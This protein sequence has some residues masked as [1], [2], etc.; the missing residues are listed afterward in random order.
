MFD[1]LILPK[2]KR[3]GGD[4]KE[5]V[6][7]KEIEMKRKEKQDEKMHVDMLKK[8]LE[9]IKAKNADL[10]KKV[11]ELSK[12]RDDLKKENGELKANTEVL[13]KEINCWRDNNTHRH[14]VDS[15]RA[16]KQPFINRSYTQV[17]KA[18]NEN[19]IREYEERKRRRARY[20]ILKYVNIDE[21]AQ[22]MLKKKVTKLLSDRGIQINEEDIRNVS[23]ANS[24][25]KVIMIEM[26]DE[27]SAK[28][29]LYQRLILVQA[30]TPF[31]MEAK[32]TYKER[33]RIAMRKYGPR[34]H[35]M[36]YRV[37]R[38]STQPSSTS[39]SVA[40]AATTS[41]SSSHS[42]S[43]G[44]GGS[45]NTPLVQL[46]S[47]SSNLLSPVTL[48]YNLFPTS[49]STCNSLHSSSTS[50]KTF[51]MSLSSSSYSSSTSSSQYSML[52]MSQSSAP[53]HSTQSSIDTIAL[54]SVTSTSLS[55]LS[56]PL[57]LSLSSPYTSQNR[58]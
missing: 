7:K 25:R 42:S 29:I 46:S 49:P 53:T 19:E 18:F 5:D 26:K 33:R 50:Y 39:T 24:N 40:S 48:K 15:H 14:S 37:R 17:T 1:W 35:H 43:T 41:T 45:L 51:P 31:I 20:V 9:E 3:D 23:R 10:L 6:K 11:K 4:K 32:M 47:T 34:H 38:T 44:R 58:L 2:P 36:V 54:S 27:E 52:P 16:T 13:I 22:E 8:E 12:E 57:S 28:N 30:N 21:N 56:S 55:S